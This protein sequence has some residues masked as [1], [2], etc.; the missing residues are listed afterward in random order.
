MPHS[1]NTL[2]GF[3][4]GTILSVEGGYK[5][6]PQT[7]SERIFGRLADAKWFLALQWCEQ[8]STPAGILT[9]VGQIPFHNEPALTLGDDEFIP[10][11]HRPTIFKRCLPLKPLEKAFYGIPVADGVFCRSIEIQGVEI[12]PRYGKVALVHECLPNQ[13][14]VSPSALSALSPVMSHQP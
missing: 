7:P 10:P 4:G 2:F 14:I 8:F 3:L 11:E 13:S 12:D 6:L 5:V 1:I 9:N